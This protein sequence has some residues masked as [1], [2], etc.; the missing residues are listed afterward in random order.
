V[1]EETK[2][3]FWSWH[4]TTLSEHE[5]DSTPCCG[6]NAPNLEKCTSQS[7]A[8]QINLETR[9]IASCNHRFMPD[10]LRIGYSHNAC[11][12]AGIGLTG[13]SESARE[14]HSKCNMHTIKAFDSCSL[15]ADNENILVTLNSCLPI[16][17]ALFP[18]TECSAFARATSSRSPVDSRHTRT[19]P[20]N[21]VG[22]RESAKELLCSTVPL[23][24]TSPIVNKF[25]AAGYVGLVSGLK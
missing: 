7:S 10:S 21:D 17:I 18:R 12:D 2:V 6:Q 16:H 19:Y 15:D 20:R 1:S 13:E 3:R 9:S 11:H 24:A 25:V 8:A 23:V 4:R 5:V 22:C 14:S